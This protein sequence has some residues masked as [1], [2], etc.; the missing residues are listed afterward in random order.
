MARSQTLQLV[1]RGPPSALARSVEDYLT[2]CRAR[3]LAPKTVELGY[4]WPLVQRFLPWAAK[5]GIRTP[6]D[7]SRRALES[8]SAYL[9]ASPGRGGTG[10]LSRHTVHTYARAVNQWVRWAKLEGEDVP[11]RAQAPLPKLPRSL[12]QV[13]CREQIDVMEAA[14][15][16]ERDRLIIRLLADT[17]LRVG[18]LVGLR[19]GDVLQ[20]TRG[21]FL[22]IRGKGDRERQVPV[23][24]Q[25]TRRLER[26]IAKTRPKDVGGDRVFVGLRRSAT[27]GDYE[28][29]TP[30]GVQ[31]LVRELGR[32]CGI[33]GPVHPHLFRHSF[34]TWAL[35]RSM[36]P[37]QLAE[38]LGHT[39]LAMIQQVYSHLSPSD[40]YDAMAAMLLRSDAR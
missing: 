35:S 10:T 38:I 1:R 21:S 11:D 36:N 28:P 19:T 16:S 29:L 17:G 33:P 2:S 20:R 39:S 25:L 15:T 4:G 40:A 23:M 18:E 26:Y 12:P 8:Y 6:A 32:R 31:Q 5:E 24:P 34:A 13:L 7:V 3:G 22:R 30:S 14:A 37:I 9:L 27:S